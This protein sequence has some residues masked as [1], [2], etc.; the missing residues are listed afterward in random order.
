MDECSEVRLELDAYFSG[1]VDAGRSTAIEEHLRACPSCRAECSDVAGLVTRLR[2]FGLRLQP[3][4]SFTPDIVLR[5]PRRRLRVAHVVAAAAFVCAILGTAASLAPGLAEWITVLPVGGVLREQRSVIAQERERADRAD[6]EKAELER[7]LTATLFVQMPAGAE[8]TLTE[9][10]GRLD[11]SPSTGETPSVRALIDP[12]GTGRQPSRV[13][14]SSI[15]ALKRIGS[16]GLRISARLAVHY[17]GETDTTDVAVM[18]EMSRENRGEWEVTR[19]V[20]I[21]TGL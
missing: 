7:T 13:R 12:L 10:L 2:R 17:P 9:Y 14:L 21:L 16:K 11:L 1:E 19:V 6:S 18:I 15:R 20:K 5:K 4:R 8:A 3:T